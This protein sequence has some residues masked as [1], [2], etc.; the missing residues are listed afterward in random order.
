MSDMGRPVAVFYL[1]Y[2]LYLSCFV[3]ESVSIVSF[4]VVSHTSTIQ[5]FA[6][7]CLLASDLVDGEQV[8]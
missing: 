3:A 4:A 8:F 2:A 6:S 5:A 1:Y 7:F